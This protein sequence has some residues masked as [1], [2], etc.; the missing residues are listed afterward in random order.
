MKGITGNPAL[1]AYQR[2]AVKPVSSAQQAQGA[3]VDPAS[4]TSTKAAKVSISAEARE[5]AAGNAPVNTQKVESLRA[6]IV[7]GS[8]QVNPT[9]VA[10]RML[11]G[12]GA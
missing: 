6:A 11:D 5:L 7:D 8:F 9:L 1:E 10:Q 4:T 2:F 12:V 3:G